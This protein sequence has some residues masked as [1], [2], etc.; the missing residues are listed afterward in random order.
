MGINS[1]ITFNIKGKEIAFPA[2][3]KGNKTIVSYNKLRKFYFNNK[4][5]YGIND[6]IKFCDS[7]IGTNGEVAHAFVCVNLSGEGFNGDFIGEVTSA[8]YR[9]DID[10]KFPL[11]IALNRALSAALLSYFGFPDKTYTT[12]Q[13]LAEDEEDTEANNQSAPTIGENET[14]PYSTDPKAVTF[15]DPVKQEPAKEEVPETTPVKEETTV[16]EEDTTKSEDSSV[17]METEV[18]FGKYASLSIA[19]LID[20]K[21][22]GD[23]FAVKF[24]GM[25]KSGKIVQ[26]TEQGKAVINF[27]KKN[28]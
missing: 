21:N 14:I 27:I 17:T 10:K 18:G 5:E 15:P 1:T 26:Q 12:V 20:K 4:E 13:F 8:E 25:I 22:T 2:Y 16:T 7:R 19:E 11:A 6:H 23:D 24:I 28:V 9:D 3:Q